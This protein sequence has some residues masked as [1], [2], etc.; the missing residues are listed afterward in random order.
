MKVRS[1]LAF[2][3]L[4]IALAHPAFCL[5]A[6]TPAEDFTK[7]PGYVDFNMLKIFGDQEPK[8]EINLKKPLLKLASEFS[9]NEDPE[10]FDVMEELV[11][12][13]VFVFDADEAT[14][15]KFN[16]ESSKT[17]RTLDSAGWERIVSVHDADEIVYVYVKPSADASVIQ[18]IVVIA[19]EEGD[20]A[21]F[22]NIV[23]NM[24]PEQIGKLGKCFDIKELDSLGVKKVEEHEEE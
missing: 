10:L 19:I 2:A 23:G 9:K 13:R 3:I 7:H 16:A 11:L 4:L 8:V 24:D 5:E 12:V 1:M 21:V 15:K 22:V 6:E 18:G 14:A 20:E 17:I